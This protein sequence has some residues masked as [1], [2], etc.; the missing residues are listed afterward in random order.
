MS[1]DKVWDDFPGC[2]CL[3]SI[4]IQSGFDNAASLMCINDTHIENVEKFVEEN[5]SL[6]E[7]M[8]CGHANSYSSMNQFKFLPGH[9]AILLDWCQNKLKSDAESKKFTVENAA[10]SPI[11][12][13]ILESALTNH[14]KPKNAHRFSKLLMEFSIHVYIMVGKASYEILCAN[15]PLPKSGT[16]GKM[17]SVCL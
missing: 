3:K 11:L 13:E 15:L 14:H 9:R 7:E 5:R 10:F 4:L 1:S 17:T 12:R 8:K 16:V 6:V 2:V